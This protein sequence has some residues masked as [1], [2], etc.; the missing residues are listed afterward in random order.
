MAR[1]VDEKHRAELLDRIADYVEAKGLGELSLRPLAKAV[2]SSPR[3]L[4]YYFGSKDDMIVEALAC[5]R[6]RQ[7]AAF[8][9][10]KAKHAEVPGEACRRIWAALSAPKAL[11][12]FRLFLEVYNLALRKP[13][14]FGKFLEHTFTDWL[15]YLETTW[16]SDG[17]DRQDARAIATV[18]LAGF[19]GFLLDLNATGDRRRIDRAVELWLDSL[20]TFPKAATR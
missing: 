8:A 14:R 13:K 10:I 16:R 19:R 7:Q 6:A 1:T 18:V 4:L 20:E 11:K 12:V 15:A 2:S 3:V 17:Y 9:R 5:L